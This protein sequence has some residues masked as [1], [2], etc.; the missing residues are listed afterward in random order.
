[1]FSTSP[2]VFNGVNVFD[3]GGIES[4]VERM[5]RVGLSGLGLEQVLDPSETFNYEN[6]D[7][8]KP[9]F[10]LPASVSKSLP[11]TVRVNF[12]FN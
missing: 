4:A 9:N 10:L 5:R 12:S 11:Q 6:S 8:R 3:D 7:L 2:I 1:M